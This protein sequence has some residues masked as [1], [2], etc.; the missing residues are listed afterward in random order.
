MSKPTDHRSV[1]AGEVLINAVIIL[2]VLGALF[3]AGLKGMI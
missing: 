3:Y 1:R 2:L